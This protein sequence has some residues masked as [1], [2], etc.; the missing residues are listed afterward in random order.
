LIAQLQLAPSVTVE[1]VEKARQRVYG[2]TFFLLRDKEIGLG[3]D[4]D[5]RAVGE[6]NFGARIFAGPKAVAHLKH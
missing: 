6:S 1:N 2:H 4:L 3:P 5:R